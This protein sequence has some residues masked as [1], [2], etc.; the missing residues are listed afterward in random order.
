[1]ASIFQLVNRLYTPN[2][3]NYIS[4]VKLT[5]GMNQI[6]EVKFDLNY[7]VAFEL[8]KCVKDYSPLIISI[9]YT[10]KGKQYAMISYGVFKKNGEGSINGAQI[11]KQV[12]LINGMPF[13]L[14]SIYGMV[15]EGET[16]TGE[17]ADAT[18]IDDPAQ[19]E[20]VICLTEESNTVIMPCGHF[21]ICDECGRALVKAKQTCPICRNNISNLIPM[22]RGA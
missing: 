9:N 21:C 20:C 12:I 17:S 14:K 19:R 4:E 13:E 7:L 8:T 5:P 11:I 16:V 10:D 22:K 3:T 18:V 6:C 2:R 15:E 1:M